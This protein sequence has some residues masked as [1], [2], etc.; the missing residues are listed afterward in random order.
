MKNKRGVLYVLDTADPY[1]ASNLVSDK[2]TKIEIDNSKFLIV[3]FKYFLA[4]IEKIFSKY[5]LA[6]IFCGKPCI[7]YRPLYIY[8]IIVYNMYYIYTIFSHVAKGISEL[9][10]WP[11]L[12]G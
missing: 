4:K 6:A 7:Y 8:Y 11:M 2:L 3:F 5:L 1:I 9:N 10:A 12:H